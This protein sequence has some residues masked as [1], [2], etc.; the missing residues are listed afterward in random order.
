MASA[1]GGGRH[2]A[3]GR[4]VTRADAEKMD[5]ADPLAGF[6]QRFVDR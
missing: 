2:P 5:A 3:Y 4:N 6:R 1:P